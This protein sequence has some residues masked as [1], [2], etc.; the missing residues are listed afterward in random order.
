[1]HDS[2]VRCAEPRLTSSR[3]NVLYATSSR[4]K[5]R[6]LHASGPLMHDSGSVAQSF[7]QHPLA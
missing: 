2:G 4:A 7:A 5:V 6:Y 1:M 3:A